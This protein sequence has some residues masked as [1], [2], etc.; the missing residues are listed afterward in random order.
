[1]PAATLAFNHFEM[2]LNLPKKIG[3]GNGKM[4]SDIRITS[5]MVLFKKAERLIMLC[6]RSI[7]LISH[8]FIFPNSGAITSHARELNLY[9]PCTLE[10]TILFNPKPLIYGI[11]LT[12][13]QPKILKQNMHKNATR[14][15]NI[16]LFNTERFPFGNP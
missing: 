2:D 10:I 7:A 13:M 3:F 14:T 5:D 15:L 6:F 12:G 1:M 16:L 11:L 9:D 8:S 4:F